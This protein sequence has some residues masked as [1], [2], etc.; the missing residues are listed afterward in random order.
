VSGG[1]ILLDRPLRALWL[2]L[3][4]AGVAVLLQTILNTELV[5]YTM[6]RASR[7]SPVCRTHP[8]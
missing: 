4:A 1:A 8:N 6:P 5:R 2:T 3:P 7:R